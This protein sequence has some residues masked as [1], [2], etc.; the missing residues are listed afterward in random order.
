MDRLDQAMRTAKRDDTLVIVLFVDLDRFKQV[1]DTFGHKAGDALLQET[2]QRLGC[3]VRDSDTVARLSGDEFTAI[4]ERSHL[5]QNAEVVAK[6]MLLALKTD[7]IINDREIRIGASIGI[8][9]YPHDAQ[10]RDTLLHHADSAMYYAKKRGRNIFE[11]F[12]PKI[13]AEQNRRSHIEEDLIVAIGQEELQLHYQPIVDANNLSI[14]GFEALLR[15]EHPTMGSISPVEFITIA[16]TSGLIKRL[17]EWAL[18]KACR[19][20]KQ[21]HEAGYS[22][23]SISVNVSVRQFHLTDFALDV[24]RV[25]REVEIVPEMVRLEVTESIVM[26]IPE[27]VI[28]MLHVIK[29]LG[30]NLSID[31]FGTGYSSLSYLQRFPIDTL[32]IDRSFT[33]GIGGAGGGTEIT[34][35]IISMA[36]SLN[37]KVIAEGIETAEQLAFLQNHQCDQLQGFYFSPPVPATEV[38]PLLNDSKGTK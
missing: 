5:E 19:Q 18:Q 31:D 22:D 38:I 23:L 2:A 33:A 8:S 36:H 35:A 34:L 25:L 9:V 20:L 26:D 21:W 15:W 30:V 13:H 3:C 37:L 32:K 17:G 28:L 7:F 27:K 14:V 16:E 29:S 12:D 11:F 24:A 1:N 10:D 4:L 6:R